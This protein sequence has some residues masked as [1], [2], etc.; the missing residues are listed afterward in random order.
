MTKETPMIGYVTLGT[1]DLKYFGFRLSPVNR[2]DECTVNRAL[3]HANLSVA[4]S[5][6]SFG[7]RFNPMPSE[8]KY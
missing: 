3:E 5:Q 2:S 6:I 8:T 7:P 4:A 1:K